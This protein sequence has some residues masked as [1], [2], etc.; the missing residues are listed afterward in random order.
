MFKPENEKG[1]K[2][3]L[4]KPFIIYSVTRIGFEPMTPSLEGWCSIQLSYRAGSPIV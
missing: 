2:P 1:L 4:D 3:L